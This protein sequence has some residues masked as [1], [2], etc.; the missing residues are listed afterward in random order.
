[1][2][3]LLFVVVIVLLVAGFLAWLV[4]TLPFIQEPLKKIVSGVILFVA[5]IFVL[6]YC[7]A[8]FAGHSAPHVGH[9]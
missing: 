7:Y 4:Q 6:Y 8:F 2:I 1:M 3:E 5:L 9:I